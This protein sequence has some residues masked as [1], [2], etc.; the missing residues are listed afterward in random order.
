MARWLSGAIGIAALST[1]PLHAQLDQMHWL[2]PA[3]TKATGTGSNVANIGPHFIVITT[4]STN[5]V[6]VTVTDG[7][8]NVILNT[9]VS[10]SAPVNYQIG[11]LAVNNGDFAPTVPGTSGGVIDNS[12]LNQILTEGFIVTAD[13]PVFVNLR[14][15]SRSQGA[16]LTSKGCAALGTEFRAGFMRSLETNFGAQ[17][18]R[19]HAISVMATEDNT[20]VRF[21]DFKPGVVVSGGT[22]T[23]EPTAS[24][25]PRT[26]E[27]IEVT[28]DAGETYSIGLHHEFLAGDGMTAGINDFNGTRVSSDKSIVVS[29]STFLDSPTSSGARDAGFDQIAPTA[30]AGTEY[31]M[32]IGGAP[33]TSILE[34]PMVVATE[35]NTNIFVNGNL[36]PINPTPLQPGDYFYLDQQWDVNG[37]MYVETSEPVMM[38]ATTA[39]ANSSATPGYSFI[40]PL[41]FDI[42][43][44]V[45]NIAQVNQI[46][47]AI[48]RTV[49]TTGST[50]TYNGN[51]P[52]NGPIPVSGNPSWVVYTQSNMTGDVAVKSTGPVAVSVQNFQN[53]VGAQGYFSGFPEFRPEIN[54]ISSEDCFP[55]L[56]L[57]VVDPSGG[58]I[59]AF[60]WF[61]EDGSSTGV[62]A[63]TFTPPSAG[64]YFV[65]GLLSA[66][67]QC[68]LNDSAVFTVVECPEADVALEKTVSPAIAGV[69]STVTFTITVT[70]NGPDDAP[71]VEVT[72]LIPA[73]YTYVAGSLTGAD[74]STDATP[75]SGTGL[76]W[77]IL[78]LPSAAGSNVSVLSFDA[79]VNAN[80]DYINSATVTTE[81]INDDPSN[82][83]DTAAIVLA[84]P[85]IEIEKA[86]RE[87]VDNGNGNFT[88]IYDVTLANT[89]NEPLVNVQIA[90]AI[91]VA[92]NDFPAGS[93]ATASAGAGLTPSG[94]FN[95]NTDTNVLSGTDT[96]PVMGSAS[97]VVSVS[98]LLDGTTPYLNQATGI[99][100]GGFG[101]TFVSEVSDDPTTVADND[102]TSV[103]PMAVPRLS[104]TKEFQSVSDVGGGM[105]AATF[106]HTIT[107]TG[108][109]PLTN[110]SLIDAVSVSPST[111][112][113]GSTA[114][115]S[116]GTGGLI[117]STTY[118]GDAV[119]E[120]L[121]PGSMI[122]QGASGSV[123]VVVTYT[124][125]SADLYLNTVEAAGTGQFSTTTVN[126]QAKAEVA[127]PL[128]PQIEVVKTLASLVEDSPGNFTA[129]FEVAVENTGNEPVT[130]IVLEDAI[131]TLPNTFPAG[132]TASATASSGGL[133]F[134]SGYDG[135]GNNSLL[136]GT[137]S[138]GVGA[139]GSV[140][141]VVN[142]ALDANAPYVNQ[143]SASVT[144]QFSGEVDS[145][146]SDDPA[147]PGVDDDPTSVEPAAIP[148]IEA[149]KVPV[150]T[151]DSGDGSFT[152]SFT[153]TLSNTGNEPLTNVQAIDAITASPSNFP[154]GSTASITAT[155]GGLIEN[156]SFTG[157]GNNNLLDA[158]NTLAVGA[159]GTVSLEVVY[160]PDAAGP[161]TNTVSATGL[162]TFSGDDTQ[163]D[164]SG[165]STPQFESAVALEKALVS[166]D[167]RGDGTFDAVYLIM[168]ENVGN[169]PLQN[170]Q[171]TDSILLAP[172]TFPSGSVA[173][174]SAPSAGFILDGGFNGTST[175]TIFDGTGTLAVDAFATATVTVTFTPEG[176][177]PYNNQARATV[178]G[179]FSGDNNTDI[180]DNPA[181]AAN[182]DPTPADPLLNPELTLTKEASPVTDLGDGTFSTEFTITVANTGNEI[183]N[184][185][186]VTDALSLPNS[187]FP[188]GT[189]GSI[190]GVTGGLTQA[191]SYSGDNSSAVADLLLSG[192]DSLGV[193][194]SGTVTIEV[195]FTPDGPGPFANQANGRADG[196]ASGNPAGDASDDPATATPND[197]TSVTPPL[198][199]GV[200]VLKELDNIADQGDGSFIA[201]YTIT[202]SNSGN[203]PLTALQV[204]DELSALPATFPA[205]AS[206]VI[207]ATTGGLTPNIAYTGIAPAVELLDSGNTL[208]YGGSG[209][210]TVD[211]L[212]T[213]D[214]PGPFANNAAADAEGEFSGTPASGADSTEVSPAFAP[215]LEVSKNLDTIEDNSDGS[216]VATYTFI[217][218][219]T[220]NEPVENIQLSDALTGFPPGSV[221]SVA[222]VGGG[223][224]AAAPAFNGGS[225]PLLL[226]G[227]DTL[228][229]G[230]AGTVVVDVLYTPDTTTPLP[231]T[232]QGT[233]TADGTYSNVPTSEPSDNPDTPG[234]DDDPTTNAPP[235]EAELS[236]TKSFV[237]TV[238]LGNGSFTSTFVLEV[239]N[240]G[241]E[242][243]NDIQI[244]DAIRVG[245][246]SYPAGSFA[247]A[248]N[249]VG[250]FILDPSYDGV[251]TTTVLSGSNSL[252]V[253]GQGSVEIAVTYTPD[254]PGP[255]LNQASVSGTGQFSM[256]AEFDISDDPSTADPEDPTAVTPPFGSGI[257]L[258]KTLSG[259][260]E[261]NS[262]GTFTATFVLEVTNSG[263]EPL[264]SVQI[265]DPLSTGT[266]TFPAGTLGI[267]TGTSG[268]LTAASLTPFD[269]QAA[270]ALLTGAD[271]LG[272]GDVGTVTVEVDFTPD[273]QQPYLNQATATGSGTFGG[274]TTSD[275]SD[276]PTIDNTPD[277]PTPVNPPL[278]AEMTVTK[279]LVD[280][281]DNGDGSFTASYTVIVQN[282]G[283]EPIVGLSVIDDITAGTDPF[284]GGSSASVT[285][286]TSGL[287]SN[288][289]YDGTADAELVGASQSVPVGGIRTIF[290]DVSFTPDGQQPYTN[291]VNAT[292]SGFAS[293]APVS[294]ASS[295][296]VDPPIVPGVDVAKELGAVLYNGDG[297]FT[298]TYLF[299]VTNSG[300]EPLEDI[301][302]SDPLSG[303]PAGSS[304]TLVRADAPLTGDTNYNGGT[305]AD[306]LVASG[307]TLPVNG[308]AE[309]EIAVTFTPDGAGPFTNDASVSAVGSSSGD[310]ATG[311][312]DAPALAPQFNPA[313]SVG[314]SVGTVDD[315]GD[316]TFTAN[317]TVTATNIGNEPLV[318]LQVIDAINAAPSSFP[319]G[320]TATVSGAGASATY[321]GIAATGLFAPSTALAVNDSIS[322]D[323]AVLFTPD[324]QQPYTNS[325]QAS[326]NG[327]FSGG[328]AAGGS[329]DIADPLLLPSVAVT[330]TL[331]GIVDNGDGSFVATFTLAVSNTGNEVLNAVNVVDA[332]TVLPSTFP[333]TSLASVTG[334]TGGLTGNPLYDGV[335]DT[336]ALLGSDTLAVNSGGT[337][338]IDVVFT[339]DSDLA[340]GNSASASATGGASG[341]GVSGESAV[342]EAD[343]PLASAIEVEKN[344]DMT[345]DNSGVFTSTFTISV[346]NTGN[347]PVE[348]VQVT[349]NLLDPFQAPFDSLTPFGSMTTA[350]V[351]GTSGLTA[352]TDPFDGTANFDLLTGTDTLAVGAVGTITVDV[353]FT[354][355]QGVPTLH[356]QADGS[357]TGAFTSTA[358][359][360]P[361]NNPDTLADDDDPTPSSPPFAGEMDVTKALDEVRDNSDGTFT[362]IFTLTVENT[363]N[364]QLDSVQL[365]DAIT[366]APSTFPAGS[367]AVSKDP[368]NLT[369]NPTAWDG[370]AVTDLF[371]GSDSLGVGLSG[372]IVIEVTFTPDGNQPYENQAQGT[373]V[374]NSSN[375]AE[376]DLSDDPATPADPADP[377]IASPDLVPEIS[378]TKDLVDVVYNGDGNFT[379]NFLV[380]VENT[381]NEVLDGVQIVDDIT[382][383]PS[384]FPVGSIASV[385]LDSGS[386]TLNPDYD[387]VTETALL[388]GG[389]SLPVTAP[390]DTAT[391][392]VAVVFLPDGSQ[393]YGNV[394]QA[395]GSGNASGA[396]ASDES[397]PAIANPGLAPSLTLEKEAAPTVA[398]NG[399]G[400]FTASYTLTIENTGNERLVGLQVTDAV[401]LA[402]SEFPFGSTASITGTTG[403]FVGNS[404]FDGVTDVALLASGS[405]LEVNSSGTIDIEVIFTPD[406][407]QPYVN[408]AEASAEGD[409]S[410]ISAGDTADAGAVTP[411]LAP[412]I[413]LDKT[414]VSTFDNGDLS[415]TTTFL[416]E[417]TNTGNEA[418]DSVQ[419]DDALS[420]FPA[421]FSVAITGTTGSLTPNPSYSG[422]IPNAG[423]LSGTDSLAFGAG[424]S[425]TLEV[426]Y[427]PDGDQPY[428]NSAQASAVGAASGGDATD[429]AVSD[430]AVP[431][432]Q[433][434]LTLSKE[435]VSVA[436]SGLG[437][438]SFVAVFSL[439]VENTGNEN[440]VGLQIDDPLTGFPAGTQGSVTSTDFTASTTYNGTSNTLMLSGGDTLGFQGSGVVTLEVTFTPDNAGP[441]SNQATASGNGEA[442]GESASDVSDDPVGGGNMDVTPLTPP[443]ATGL[444]VEKVLDGPVVDDGNGAFIADY[445]IT[446]RNTGNEPL[447][448]VQVVDAITVAPA[449]FPANA[450]AAVTATS[451][452]LT[453]STAMYDGIVNVELLSG[454]DSLAVG[455][456]ETISVSVRFTPD[457]NVTLVNNA[458]GDGEGVF[459]GIPASDSGSADADAPFVSQLEIEKNLDMIDDLGGGQFKSTFTFDI[460]NIGNEPVVNIQVEDALENFPA[461][462]T[463]AAVVGT[464][465]L[466]EAS[467]P[468]YDG[469]TNS[470]LLS[471]SDSLAVGA[472][473][474]I[475]VEVT[476]TAESGVSSYENQ[477]TATGDGGFTGAMT[478][479]PSDN[480][481]TP[482][483][484]DDA[485]PTQPPFAAEMQVSKELE[486]IEDNLDGTFTAVFRI[487]ATN[488]GNEQ[489]ED[490]QISD[491]ITAAPST[492]PAGSTATVVA[493]PGGFNVDTDYDGFVPNEMLLIG[494]DILAINE[495]KSVGLEVQFTPVDAVPVLNRA[496]G[497]A[498]GSNS[499]QEEFDESDDPATPDDTND[500]TAVVAP[501]AASLDITK[502]LVA[503]VSD[504]G[505]G[506]FVANYRITV[507]NDGNELMNN[508][509][510]TDAIQ[511]LPSTFPSGSVAEASNPTGGLTLGGGYDGVMVTQ[512]L[513][514]SDSLAVNATGT[515]DVAVTFTPDGN[516][517][518]TNIATVDGVGDASGDSAVDESDEVAANPPL[519]PSLELE[520]ALVATEDI[521]DGSF[522]ST[523]LFTVTNAGNEPV[524]NVQITDALTGFP[525]GTVGEVGAVS[526][527]LVADTGYTGSAP[528]TGLLTSASNLPFGGSG[529]V[530]LAVTFTPDGAGP[531][532][533]G[534]VVGGSGTFSGTPTEDPSEDVEVNPPFMPSITIEKALDSL[535][536]SGNGMFTATFTLTVSNTGNEPL[537]GVQII[538]RLTVAPN[539]FPDNALAATIATTGPLTGSSTYNG[540]DD[541][542]V[543]S[544]NDTLPVGASGS[545]TIAVVFTPVDNTTYSNAAAANGSGANS[546]AGV[547]DMS[548]AAFA[549]PVLVSG[550]EVSKNLDMIEDLGGGTFTSTFTLEVRNTGN[551][552]LVG[553]QVEDALANFPAPGTTAVVLNT[554]NLTE[555]V[556]PVYDGQANSLLLSGTDTLAVGGVGTVTFAVT[557]TAE[558]GVSTYENQATGSGTGEFT[559]TPVSEPSDNPDTPLND[560]DAT[561]TSPPFA[562][563]MQISK[564]L[565]EVVD[566]GDGSFTANF[567]VT[568]TNTGNEQLE[569]VQISDAIN[570]APSTFPADSTAE[571][572]AIPGGLAIDNTYDG[573]TPNE[574]LL[575]GTDILA[576]NESKSVGLSVRF[577]P[578]G[579]QPYLNSAAGTAT[580][581]NS[582]QIEFDESD[583]PA[584][585]DDPNDPTSANPPLAASISVSKT[586]DP[587]V[588]DNDDG[589]FTSTFTLTVTNT[590]NEPLVGVQVIDAIQAMPSSFPSGSIASASNGTGGLTPNPDYDG[591]GDTATLLGM[592]TLAFGAS[593]TVT[594]EVTYTPDGNQPYI[595]VATASGNGGASGGGATD[596][597]DESE[598]T[599]PL[600]PS[601]EL[602]KS[603]V[604]IEDN[605]D[606]TFVA[607]YLF[608]VTNTGNEPVDT[609]QITDALSD[610]PIGTVGQVGVA[611]GGLVANT[612]YT[613]SAPDTALLT[614]SSSLPFEGSGTVSL[615]VTFTPD[616]AGPFIN[617][618][619]VGGSGTFSGTP[620]EDLSEDTEANPPFMPSIMVE[621]SLDSLEDSGGGMFTATFT[622]TVSNTGNEPLAGVQ[623]TDALT[624]A[625]NTFPG[626][627]VAATIATSG[628]LSGSS[629]YDGISDTFVLSGNDTLPVGGSGTATIAVVFTP[630]DNMTYS[631]VATANGTGAN[632]G[633]GTTDI[634]DPSFA[635]PVLGSGLEVSKNLDMVEELGGGTFTST[636][637]LEV[638]NTGNEP[639]VGVQIEDTLADFPATGTTA[640]VLETM[641]LSPATAPAYDG[642]TNSLL[643]AGTDTLA[644]D[645]VGTVTFAVTFTAEP[646]VA[647]YENQASGSGTGEFTGTSVTEP[648]DNPDTPLADDDATPTSPP[649][650]AEMQISKALD[651]VVDNGDGTFTANFTI[652]ATNTG[653]E[654]LEGVQIS[655]AITVA[656]ST[657]PADST[658]QVVAIPGGLSIDSGY[659]GFAT[660]EFLLEGNDILAIDESK[661]V[662]LSVSF[663]PDGMQPYLNSA[664]GT[665]TGSSSMQTEFD[666][667][668]DPAT[669]ED[670]NDPT[671]ATPL[672]A[673]S[674]SVSKTADP[675]VSDNGNGTFT[676]TFVLTVTNTGNEPLVGVQVTDA[677]EAMP[678]TF[679]QGSVA[680]VS[681]GTGGLTVN[682]DYDGVGNTATL[683]GSDS[684]AVNGTGS[685]T[686]EVTYIPDGNQP[687]TNVATASG[688]GGASGGGA[689]DASEESG[690]TPPLAPSLELEKALVDIEDNA[691][692]SFTSNYLFTVTNT[693]NEPV[694]S[695]QIT[696]A[697]TG[698]PAGTLGQVGVATGG[699]VADTSYTGNGSDTAL[700]T[701][702]SSL[703]FGG[704]GTVSL[705][706]TFVPDGAGPFI[707]GALVDGSGTFSG[708]PTEDPSEDTEA[709]PPFMP[710]IMVEKSLVDLEDS[711]G[712]MFTATFTLTVTNTG[713]EPLA[714]V[715]I[716][717][718]LTV[719]PNTF[720][721]GALAATIA[722]SGSLTGSMTYDGINDTFVLSGTD[723]LPIGGSGTATIAVV[724]MPVDTNPV[725][726]TASAGGMGIN[727]GGSVADS[728]GIVSATPTINGGL[729]VFK[730]LDAI[731]QAPGGGFRAIFAMTIRNTGNET[732]NNVQVTDSVSSGASTFPAGSTA[733]LLTFSPN[734]TPAPGSASYDGVTNTALLA[735]T[736]SLAVGEVGTVRIQV[737]FDGV[738]GE[739]S[740]FNQAEGSATG[741]ATGT[742]FNEPSDDPDT[743]LDD[744]PTEVA[745][746]FEPEMELVKALDGVV[747]NND[748]TFTATYTLTV[749]NTGNEELRSVRIVDFLG[750]APNNFP[751]GSSANTVVDAGGLTENPDFDGITDGEILTGEDSIAASE[752]ASVQIQVRF[753]PDGSGSYLNQARGIAT[754]GSSGEIERDRSDD[755]A[756][757]DDPEDPTTVI[758]MV[759]TALGV[760]KS[761]ESSSRNPDG[762]YTSRF[763][764]VVAN[765][766]DESVEGIQ[767]SDA[768]TVAPNNLPGFISA[769]AVSATPPL[770]LATDDS[771]YDGVMNTGLLSGDDTLTVGQTATITLDVTYRPVRGGS[772]INVADA[773]GT[774]QFTRNLAVGSGSTSVSPDPGKPATYADFVAANEELLGPDFAPT[775]NPDGDLYNNALEYALCLHPADGNTKKAFC[776]DRNSATGQ[777]DATFYRALNGHAD[778]TYILEGID[779]ISDSPAGWFPI[780]SISASVDSTSSDVPFDAE[781][782]TF[783]GIDLAGEFANVDSGFAR[784]RVDV[785]ADGNGVIASDESHVTQTFGWKTPLIEAECETFSYPF[786]AKE[787]FSGSILGNDNGVLDISAS[788]APGAG[789]VAEL[790]AAD[791]DYYVEMIGGTYEGHRFE[792]DEAATVS[793]T[794][795]VLEGGSAR[796]TITPV[797]A[798]LAGPFVLRNHVTLEDV[799]P[800]SLFVAD[801]D[802]TVGNDETRALILQG[803]IWREFW[804]YDN[805][806]TEP[807]RW[808]DKADSTFADVGSSTV[809]P[810]CEGF[811]LHPKTGAVA[812]PVTGV[813]RS[814]D[815]A[816][817]LDQGYNLVGAAYPISQSPDDRAMGTPLFTGAADPGG[818]DQIEIWRGDLG[819]GIEGYVTYYRSLLPPVLDF[820]T[821]QNNSN[822]PDADAETLFGDCRAVF[823]DS[824][825]G[826]DRTDPESIWVWPAPWTP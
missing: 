320:S 164:G 510:I 791:K 172:S 359:N 703:P 663:T 819:T 650:A 552:P 290:V 338:T 371:S 387:G 818:A 27:P 55:G 47:S 53:P 667:S 228:A 587:D 323:V 26:T 152:A 607:N 491:A 690:T 121:D 554:M 217:V 526:G 175:T 743:L 564:A 129:T 214:G 81:A 692:G 400:T 482:G 680:S 520:K 717:D 519:V 458:T 189:T 788:V 218:R 566:N 305:M 429:D 246:S 261:D 431:P 645:G 376:A 631:N 793:A 449:N 501:I 9:T 476:F 563:E 204:T 206:G 183:L 11:T 808:A 522:T 196:D 230:A 123:Q 203:E 181:T 412:A 262:D 696:D 446:V 59:V 508:V 238:D 545:A 623:I 826:N 113:A 503:P 529:T 678:S 251:N 682:P 633:N 86:F 356:N 379:A 471:G 363:G 616:G 821:P 426:T 425:V 609:V 806:G 247:S 195:I 772:Y 538:D 389:D 165:D 72:D 666:V 749:V 309:I 156:P 618:A 88:A 369:P 98:F 748:G 390:G 158:G 430:P 220:G 117:A 252:A 567:T 505:G 651:E 210:I 224:G 524:D 558:S 250:G 52:A 319:A 4:P 707:N 820:W 739:S 719:A 695:V 539:T 324:G 239:T 308:G 765:S 56:E 436:D 672:L 248:S 434:N 698:F 555:A 397:D 728:S 713:N 340:Y 760:N 124:P 283:N 801:D 294:D 515:V 562:S 783:T 745:P 626:N 594:I 130:N 223:F 810:P 466:T 679:P 462:G 298:A 147:T 344:L 639:L 43:N 624:V 215:A 823:I 825:N 549:D 592:D 448:S 593:G 687:Y 460:R 179:Q 126:E 241:N 293:G 551:E 142:F 799:A 366:A 180:S 2:P 97:V 374:G 656:P 5:A 464:M 533:N 561:P 307:S 14:Q 194:D 149:T 513:S 705:A 603:L 407:M 23:T 543:L 653:N 386:L 444:S 635:D 417:V 606:G 638:R 76:R 771:A 103:N 311:A 355:E 114:T 762:S 257:T 569:A 469:Q 716:T 306:L 274:G 278:V 814:W 8:G 199:P 60:E 222:S 314:K 498:T 30:R 658:A 93:T 753:T 265:D 394:V 571:V 456:V 797:P 396:P 641:N 684:L 232:N 418:L 413:S 207:T 200:D 167:D 197:P 209:T 148:G 512:L 659:T 20:V 789:G 422:I 138:L 125:D 674:I 775:D 40:P 415:F 50:V 726:N 312:A 334:T 169:E 276:D 480:P 800:A 452:G 101:G 44:E 637:T 811:F 336:N 227:D 664:A 625:P 85:G 74:Q 302:V 120:A 69:G 530:T 345:V 486:S 467:S 226:D 805:G 531:F 221:G 1:T 322:V 269:G 242:P 185:V 70:N 411:P 184:D 435:L 277:D 751:A 112:P 249:P 358:V 255:F 761:V 18:Y 299:T 159:S 586:A 600:A 681:N 615:A 118:D 22:Q 461:V 29:T 134:N 440:L 718:A 490:V 813:V 560:D 579:L 442:S 657:F 116:L 202:V 632:S 534:A 451:P 815:F 211:V 354:G 583:D 275:L 580:G 236:V 84:V 604:D 487:T 99:A 697:L 258:T 46:G 714:G 509:Q 589:T 16:S 127:T 738:S 100:R 155:T 39:G 263:N 725:S 779:S 144:G 150:A 532:I 102:P 12:Q 457:S 145:E 208:S 399:N 333:S 151:V 160:T 493:I 157:T 627:A 441:Y 301:Q 702:A 170:V 768:L 708:T 146:L 303:F 518:Y 614:D 42:S 621:K 499:G 683:L 649:F 481:D 573:F 741:G 822:L 166:V 439:T 41:N 428:A 459:S 378:V 350:S 15:R 601:L 669:P 610:F 128:D 168:V 699:L 527:G 245:A 403:G 353:V 318:D 754:G 812:V 576:I 139:S 137:N 332:I 243:F 733:S 281:I 611:T 373:A 260:I 48:V 391:L 315:N 706:V 253:A 729:E 640:V 479:E 540:I 803:S 347:E 182:N 488:T 95:G 795:I 143:A 7:A 798:V 267:V 280:T 295:S 310:D 105:F 546:G 287:V 455:G 661:S 465:N 153:I 535:E 108:S 731:I 352:S 484:D 89:G 492:F 544:G 675:D 212:F 61:N 225:Q 578:D 542:F 205:G 774:G 785:D 665:A 419:I 37:N 110:V 790:L 266:S 313:V 622:L 673:P 62:I 437:D 300:N 468:A 297:S 559:N 816:C 723:T 432:L 424:G 724:F 111:F 282:D 767:V 408:H 730:N 268:G 31:I 80:T 776:I 368:V 82:N 807:K 557:F 781:R 35:A 646:G 327:G 599:P 619:T 216:F 83:T 817:P 19:N 617:G 361:S 655:D 414:N 636:F 122:A 75:D 570:V 3:V 264:Q 68:A 279:T 755:P 478:S 402:P 662:G 92:P 548:D 392:S 198:A 677:I 341:T 454:M 572:F 757:D 177:Q 64:G 36:S 192:T 33:T 700:L 24:G 742:I 528:N 721:G 504:I 398:D 523:Y 57:E 516:Q 629:T 470:L 727:S 362:A 91:M 732:L 565:D 65:R 676:S 377:T 90:D 792:I 316:G 438:G 736:D 409:A 474:T 66:S 109:E 747:S 644:V 71:E 496:S 58:L 291:T 709:N 337:V 746:P 335:N 802:P 171:V 372:S 119:T 511:T 764:I 752:F 521:G 240:T 13:E 670:P 365:N 689:T 201:T 191:A 328:D 380:T 273:G 737:F 132:S 115:A 383:M 582:G 384:T 79:T 541:V 234:I 648:S 786:A 360:E 178:V 382:S 237:E 588:S 213:P 500:P 325:V 704:S 574:S 485:T 339:P 630:V 502:E 375:E 489:L 28:L 190:T 94:T 416:L 740:F 794:S 285:N 364:E 104:V 660:N 420:D 652:T 613:G 472:M 453:A 577:T 758:P 21:D 34:S 296:E 421:G 556:S 787:C 329:A 233:A 304:A 51:P 514:G 778:V 427:T 38:Y 410:S 330:K 590:G 270:T 581:S 406:G 254:G 450:V 161:F 691:D 712:G 756:T 766:G 317:F 346:R 477:A 722:T 321:D 188:A 343:A 537:A 550:L 141:L 483:A 497:A 67:A 17:S 612:N 140:T 694:S 49:T 443:F 349:D 643:L 602:E 6:P 447:A 331:D 357:A 271:T 553:V 173:V 597:S 289:T 809:I 342:A 686:I 25:T 517:P 154:T 568:A 244:T 351:T 78:S 45:D 381:G 671:V 326:A 259:D 605:N 186:Q 547:S 107:N 507:T 463:T 433:P 404:G 595:N 782:V 405:V 73:G 634:S 585:P 10:N 163:D 720:P 286:T 536:D 131:N 647:V 796:D 96:I 744:D 473:G 475:T 136:A 620:T 642:Q 231:Y 596:T 710:S 495:S 711:G 395:M 773:S 292:G 628:P 770:T 288:A 584:T 284:P 575:D 133:G 219:N 715:Q 401:T 685:V 162:G 385:S 777:I 494:D 32:V 654:Q 763:S 229:V 591:V 176:G 824:I 734:L 272:V 256:E 63:D 388:T 370:L 668:D 135:V 506:M 759:T 735:G 54:I 348:F 769:T 235:F 608:T 77:R 423:L 187:S 525:I 701:S 174:A 393:P 804:V 193:G 750:V 784:L 445:I 688:N 367:T 693:G 780:T 87:L 598:T 106:L